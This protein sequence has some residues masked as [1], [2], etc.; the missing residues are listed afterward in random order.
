M[1]NS[2]WPLG[3]GKARVAQL[4]KVSTDLACACGHPAVV[5]CLGADCQ[6]GL[7]AGCCAATEGMCSACHGQHE[8]PQAMLERVWYQIPPKERQR[9][10]RTH[11]SQDECWS[12][13]FGEE[14]DA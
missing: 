2:F 13:F 7:C 9:F 14:G 10:L 8:T 6:A 4:L 12:L 1:A 11:L 3:S 5:L